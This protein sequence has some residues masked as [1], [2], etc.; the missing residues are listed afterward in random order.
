MSI[1]RYFNYFIC[2]CKICIAFVYTQINKKKLYGQNIWLIR[3]KHTEARD[4][5]FHLYKYIRENHPE[6]NAYYT[7][8]KNNS[9]DR[10]KVLPYGNIIDS[11]SFKHYVY[12]LSAKCSIGSQLFGAC[13]YPTSFVHRFQFL[14][15]KDQKVI[16]LK[17]G[18]YKDE[19]SHDLDYAKA[20]FALICCAA[21]R[22]Q[23]FIMNTYGYPNSIAQLVGLCRYDFRKWLAAEKREVSAT[24]EECEKFKHSEFYK[25]YTQLLSNYSLLSAAK[26]S[27]YKIVFYLHYSLQS[28]SETFKPLNNEIVT[29]ADRQNYDVQQLMIE[30]SVMVTDFSSVFFDFAYM[31]KPEV[32]FQFDEEEYRAKHYA[33]GYFDYRRDGFG[34]VF[35]SSDDVV[36]YLITLMKNRCKMEQTYQEKV[37]MFFAFRDNHNCERTYKAIKDIDERE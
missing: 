3:E 1:K 31:K 2:A 29:I 17:H 30:S 11:E 21:S 10:K 18:I 16:Y 32:Y 34:P 28:Y 14:C 24:K 4:N 27:G 26:E 25:Q 19:L 7:I 37:D 36:N 22:E 12:F 8:T 13:P 9:P 33:K 6:I 20:R 35:T 5:S 23:E 15:R